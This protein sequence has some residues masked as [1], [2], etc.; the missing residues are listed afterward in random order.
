MLLR[1]PTE[2]RN[3]IHFWYCE[4]YSRPHCVLN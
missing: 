4:G 3:D 1:H 2:V